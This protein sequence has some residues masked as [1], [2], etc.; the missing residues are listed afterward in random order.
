MAKKET[1]FRAIMREAG[2]VTVAEAAW[3]AGV[4][5]A[6]IYRL[7]DEDRV[8]ATKHGRFR[9]V[10]RESLAAY[11]TAPPIAKRIREEELPEIDDD[12]EL[13]ETGS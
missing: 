10:S 4:H 11:Y 1:R 3:L 12:L 8:E 9:F 2:W 13:E 6:T 5:A 7:L